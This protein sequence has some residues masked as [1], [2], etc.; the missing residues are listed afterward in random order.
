M[1]RISWLAFALVLLAGCGGSPFAPIED[2]PAG[3]EYSATVVQPQ[4]MAGEKVVMRLRLTNH[5]K[6]TF[7]ISGCGDEPAT[8]AVL[9]DPSETIVHDQY[10]YQNPIACD[11]ILPIPP[12][13][14]VDWTREF[15]GPLYQADGTAYFPP[16]GIYT[17][18]S[19]LDLGPVTVEASTPFAY[20]ARH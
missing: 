20:Q 19:V 2:R 14:T 4:S 16:S 12:G 5:T 15:Q 13:Q 8:Q 10:P 18:V 1:R 3:V 11:G 9:I 7:Y 17:M 6:Q